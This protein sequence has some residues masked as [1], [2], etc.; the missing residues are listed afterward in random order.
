MSK[1]IK[2]IL[3]IIF[4]ELQDNSKSLFSCL[5]VN[6]LW[7]ENVIPILWK[8]PWC[9][10]NI[11]YYNK[12]YLFMIIAS[13]LSEDIKEY[14][15]IHGI[16]LPSFSYQSLLFDYLSFCKSINT[17]VIN[18]II[19]IRNPK[20]NNQL[21]LQQL[22]YDILM[23]KC[24]EFKYLD[25]RKIEFRYRNFCLPKDK[26]R[27]ELLYELICST[28]VDSSYFYDLAR[29]SQCIQRLIIINDIK[30]EVNL[31]IAKLIEVQKNLKYFEWKDEIY[32]SFFSSIVAYNYKEILL[33]LE[34][35]ADTINH[36]NTNFKNVDPTLLYKVLP[37]FHKLKSLIINY[38]QYTSIEQIKMCTYRDLEIFK[39]DEFDLKASSIIIENSGGH[40]KKILIKPCERF[41]YEGSFNGDSLIFIRKIYENC[42]SIEYLYLTFSSSKQHFTEFE[43]LL[44]VC[45]NLKWLL[46]SIF[47]HGSGVFYEYGEKLLQILI[48]SSPTNLREI[49]F[50]YEFSCS[51]K[52]LE[53]FLEKWRGYPLSIVMYN[54][55]YK[56]NVKTYKNLIKKYKK[57][58][59][60][61]D[62]RC[63]SLAKIMDMDIKI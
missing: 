8:N 30:S 16:Q 34:K 38:F 32:Y 15:M 29:I 25:M 57:N 53:D 60:L 46:L 35:K 31:G 59:K 40:L 58:G 14:L 50:Y 39:L 48:K 11:N 23:K 12:N 21:I 41:K 43:K 51:L 1:L 4:N 24:S 5:M 62:F 55:T 49:R 10:N 27:F 61:K 7:C 22:F 56:G 3:F 45:Q 13:Y 47:N 18:I 54:Y 52:A 26:L 28:N 20:E 42:P 17:N 63:E 33:A 19:S 44:K 2:D 6:R 36:L 9:Y 37:K